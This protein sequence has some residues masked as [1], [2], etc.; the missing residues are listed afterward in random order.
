M[1]VELPRPSSPTTT[2]SSPLPFS[3]QQ[4]HL[5]QSSHSNGHPS[6]SSS[7]SSSMHR[8]HSGVNTSSHGCAP[9][10]PP[11]A[12]ASHV[13]S[14]LAEHQMRV[15]HAWANMDGEARVSIL[16]ILVLSALSIATVVMVLA[17]FG[18]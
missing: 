10:S 5:Q 14:Y 8:Y 11:T 16:G 13:K 12:K 9:A 1:A 2:S 15:R 4:A 17:T 7:P 18:L 3:I 6:A